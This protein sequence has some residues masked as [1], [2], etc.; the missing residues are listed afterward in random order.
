[1]KRGQRVLY[2]GREWVVVS[3]DRGVDQV[4][5]RRLVWDR[6]AG[7]ERRI[8]ATPNPRLVKPLAEDAR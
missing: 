7:V 3:F 1:M 2:A 4:R 5:L 6:A 8:F